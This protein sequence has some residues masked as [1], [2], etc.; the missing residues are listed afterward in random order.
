MKYPFHTPSR[1]VEGTEARRLADAMRSNEPVTNAD[2]RATAARIAAR[3][4][5]GQ[6][7]V[8]TTNAQAQVRRG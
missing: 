6:A 8:Q 4:A 2:A 3:R 5:Q 1:P 7:R